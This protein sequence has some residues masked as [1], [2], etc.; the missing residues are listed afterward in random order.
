MVGPLA[1]CRAVIA[2]SCV[3]LLRAAPQTTDSDAN[4]E[5]RESDHSA[6]SQRRPQ[7]WGAVEHHVNVERRFGRK[8]E[9]RQETQNSAGHMAGDLSKHGSGFSARRM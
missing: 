9:Q 4:R 8:H 6:T 2:M 3:P 5:R 1:R 7:P